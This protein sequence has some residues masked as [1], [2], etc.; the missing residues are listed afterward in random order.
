MQHKLSFASFVGPQGILLVIVLYVN[1]TL[2]MENAKRTPKEGLCC[3]AVNT[4]LRVCQGDLSKNESTSGTKETSHHQNRIQ[5][6]WYHLIHC[7]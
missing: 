2:L 3:Q 1:P 5:N 7:R 6:P 4:V